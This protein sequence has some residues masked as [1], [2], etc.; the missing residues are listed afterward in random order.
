MALAFTFDGAAIAQRAAEKQLAIFKQV[1]KE[2]VQ[3]EAKEN[4]EA[5]KPKPDAQ[6]RKS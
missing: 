5:A 6:Q 2:A 1:N 3:R 4:R